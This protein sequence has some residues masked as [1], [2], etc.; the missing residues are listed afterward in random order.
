MIGAVAA[1]L[2]ACAVTPPPAAS[3]AETA[4]RAAAM[5]KQD[6]AGLGPQ[7][8]ARLDQDNVQAE[9]SAHKDL[10]PAD[11]AAKIQAA[12]LATIQYPADGGL[13]GDWK[14]GEA[15]AQSGRGL[16][17]SDPPGSAAG[18]NCYACH[19]MSAKEISYGT[20][21]PSLLNYG[22]LRGNSAEIQRYTY[23]KIYN[24]EAYMPAATCRA[25]GTT[26][27]SRRNRSRIW[28]RYCSIQRRQSINERREG[29][30]TPRVSRRAGRGHGVAG[31]RR[32]RRRA[33]PPTPANCTNC[34]A[35]ATSR[36]CT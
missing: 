24:A 5:M 21:G 36:C 35:L 4:Q 26:R 11:L 30:G 10:V 8:L 33:P 7:W 22:K 2:A 16:Q 27:C 1:V 20:I 19:Q 34:R 9:C 12:Q 15:I 14:K 23:G 28:S 29:H 32:T 3:D 17:F 6:F 25:S 18:G 13:L 31:A